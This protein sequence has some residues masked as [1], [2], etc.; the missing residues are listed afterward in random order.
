MTA[1]T[2][3]KP[4]GVTI[5]LAVGAV[6][7]WGGLALLLGKQKY[8]RDAPPLAWQAEKASLVSNAHALVSARLKDP[9]SAQFGEDRVLGNGPDQR[10]C[11]SVNARNGFGGYAGADRYVVMG[12][13]AYFGDDRPTPAI[14]GR[15]EHPCDVF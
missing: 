15:P 6:V 13:M 5:A 14:W 7:V 2:M 10:I 3:R 1:I 8:D 12:G 4:D 9:D 11:G